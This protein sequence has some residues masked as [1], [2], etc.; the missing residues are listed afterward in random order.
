MSLCR[1]VVAR[2][3][4]VV[5][6]VSEEGGVGRYFRGCGGQMLSSFRLQTMVL[7][8]FVICRT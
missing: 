7:I 5:R 8:R 6:V 1:G 3:K 4:R 2:G